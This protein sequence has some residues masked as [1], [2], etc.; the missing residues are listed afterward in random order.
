MAAASTMKPITSSRNGAPM[1]PS[2]N[3]PALWRDAALPM[4]SMGP[5]NEQGQQP[6]QQQ[7][8]EP[9][10]QREQQ[11]DARR[12]PAPAGQDAADGD[13]LAAHL[14]P[15]GLVEAAADGD[16][17]ALH[18]RPGVQAH[19]A[20]HRDHVALDRAG[21]V[22]RTEHRD[23][24]A[25]ERLASRHAGVGEEADQGVLPRVHHDGA[26]VALV[27]GPHGHRA[28]RGREQGQRQQ[29]ARQKPS[30]AARRRKGDHA[31]ASRPTD[32]NMPH[33]PG[34]G[35]PRA[36]ASTRAGPRRP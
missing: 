9:A 24:V 12:G 13:A 8:R 19:R 10:R 4:R 29:G 28:R 32:A 22:G 1:K 11:Q 20:E 33:L 23:H 15:G 21:D 35:C 7:R 31:R 2:R 3:E 26:R 6:G 18:P 16:G 25:R 36:G 34:R 27:T 14:G 17:V 5:E 30:G